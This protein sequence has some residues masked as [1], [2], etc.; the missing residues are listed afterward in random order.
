[1][2]DYLSGFEKIRMLSDVNLFFG[3]GKREKSLKLLEGKSVLLV[4]SRRTQ[5]LIKSDFIYI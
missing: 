4:C 5:K 3:N 1:M 2:H